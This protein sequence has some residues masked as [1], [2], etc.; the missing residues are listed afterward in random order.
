MD[1][2]NRSTFEKAFIK[3]F[4]ALDQN[5]QKQLSKMIDILNKE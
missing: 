4:C 1:K 3:K 5:K 2:P